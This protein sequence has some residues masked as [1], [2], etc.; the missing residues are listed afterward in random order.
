MGPT[1][2]EIMLAGDRKVRKKLFFSVNFQRDL[3]H[4]GTFWSFQ[5]GMSKNGWVKSGIQK[6]LELNIIWAHEKMSQNKKVCFLSVN[7]YDFTRVYHVLT[8]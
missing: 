7:S 4:A 3:T 8:R 6:E 5:L 1:L 2:V